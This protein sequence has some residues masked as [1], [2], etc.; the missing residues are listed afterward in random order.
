M[1]VS[2][3]I[4]FI[5]LIR[6]HHQ[7]KNLVIFIP[8]FFTG[9]LFVNYNSTFLTIKLFYLFFLASSISYIINDYIDYK[10]DIYHPTKKNRPIACGIISKLEA[11]F[12]VLIL[13]CIFLCSIFIIEVKFL[14]KILILT[15]LV[16]IFLYSIILKKIPYLEILI[17]PI[18]YMIRLLISYISLE[19]IINIKIFTLL[20]ISVLFVIFLKRSAELKVAKNN[21]TRSVLE[22]YNYKVINYITL[23]IIPLITSFHIY[24]TFYSLISIDSYYLKI[25]INIIVITLLINIYYDI[26]IKLSS[27]DPILSIFKNK[28]S[29]FLFCFYILIYLFSIYLKT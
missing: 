11:K 15:Y 21:L 19:I 24:Y 4:N 26:N 12:F 13:I 5:K 14:S 20:Y 2:K 9:D 28:L 17:L 3:F 7:I 29:L 27:S 18:G 25:L 10:N 8:I 6:P 16:I 23:L 22:K 1:I